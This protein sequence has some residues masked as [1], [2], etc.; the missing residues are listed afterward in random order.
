M[1]FVLLAFKDKRIDTCESF[2]LKSSPLIK[3]LCSFCNA[4]REYGIVL[5][6]VVSS[7]YRMK[8]K[9]SDA[10]VKSFNINQE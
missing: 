2:T 3:T 5:N 4:G 1:Y 7:V 10:D 9:Y 6:N 8:E